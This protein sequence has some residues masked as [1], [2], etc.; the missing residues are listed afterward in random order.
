M[1]TRL[2]SHLPVL[3]LL[4]VLVPLVAGCIAAP[5]QTNPPQ[6]EASADAEVEDRVPRRPSADVE[7]AAPD[8]G[9]AATAV[10][11]GAEGDVVPPPRPWWTLSVEASEEGSV[12]SFP[13]QVPADAMMIEPDNTYPDLVFQWLD[14]VPVPDGDLTAWMLFVAQD[15]G[16]GMEARLLHSEAAHAWSRHDYTEVIQGKEPA[17]FLPFR[18]HGAVGDWQDNGT[19]WLILAA[20]GSGRLDV[21]FR[22]ANGS[23][24]DLGTAFDEGRTRADLLEGFAAAGP[25]E[26]LVPHAKAKGMALDWF[27]QGVGRQDFA[28][29]PVT[30]SW[31]AGLEIVGPA[32]LAAPAMQAGEVR[33]DWSAPWA[34]WSQVTWA[35]RDNLGGKVVD[36]AVN[37]GGSSMSGAM[38]GL[39]PTW[40]VRPHT[41][42]GA[43]GGDG[44]GAEA[45]VGFTMAAGGDWMHVSLFAVALGAS[46]EELTGVP[47]VP[48]R[49]EPPLVGT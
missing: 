16:S 28:L 32:N 13:W 19:V 38:V 17:A 31:T 2:P 3:V 25:H 14:V 9:P 11:S 29:K 45:K 7:P 41:A 22:V 1:A 12:A 6:A 35:T 39:G 36:Y 20:T 26:A 46:L 23:D 10:A 24:H 44:Q 8:A 42:H 18:A 34:K 43:L 47:A 40:L 5:A 48:V 21:A 33:L 4:L 49:Q 27:R 30:T 37:A 15:L